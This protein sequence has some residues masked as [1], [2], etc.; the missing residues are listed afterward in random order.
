MDF[1]GIPR[2]GL[3]EKTDFEFYVKIDGQSG[4]QWNDI[5]SGS[6]T[7]ETIQA[8]AG[9][10]FVYGNKGDDELKG[11][12]GNDTF[13]FGIGDGHDTIRGYHQ[14]DKISFQSEWQIQSR[15][16]LTIEDREE[17]GGPIRVSYGNQDDWI[18]VYGEDL[19]IEAIEF[20]F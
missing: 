11:N 20:V 2:T 10:D 9:D 3:D 19:T 13:G 16:D 14:G 15:A 12:G 1:H 17:A 4:T 7:D 5:L 6:D 8:G 18:D